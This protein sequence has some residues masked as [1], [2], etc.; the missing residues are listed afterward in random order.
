MMC[1][2]GLVVVFQICLMH[3]V[4]LVVVSEICFDVFSWF[5][6]SFRHLF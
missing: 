4:G 3:L 5:S 1:L 2:G 6:G